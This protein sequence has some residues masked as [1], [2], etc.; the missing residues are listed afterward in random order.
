MT[1]CGP[2][3]RSEAV[4]SPCQSRLAEVAAFKLLPPITGLG[5]CTATDAVELDAV[6]LPDGHRVVFFS[7]ATSRCPMAEAVGTR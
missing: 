1:V 4:V 6:R 7:S 3:P 5:D 2:P